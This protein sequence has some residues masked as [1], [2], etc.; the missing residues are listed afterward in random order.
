MYS[1][2]KKRGIKLHVQARENKKNVKILLS[3][4]LYPL[5][6]RPAITVWFSQQTYSGF[7]EPG[8]KPE[9]TA[10]EVRAV[11]PLKMPNGPFG[12]PRSISCLPR[13]F[14]AVS[15][16]GAFEMYAVIRLESGFL[17]HT[18][19]HTC[20]TS[21]RSDRKMTSEEESVVEV[22]PVRTCH[23]M[24]KNSISQNKSWPLRSS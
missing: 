13:T 19:T 6:G 22:P 23:T 9:A 4:R 12:L 2:T 11:S 20:N 24:Q 16:N 15:N 10:P 17:G 7:P 21:W 8:S 18:R 14:T 1:G 3:W 5:L